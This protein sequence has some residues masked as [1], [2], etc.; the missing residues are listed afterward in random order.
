MA[1]FAGCIGG[2]GGSGDVEPA[3]DAENETTKPS[4][5]TGANVSTTW[6]NG[7]VN[8]VGN[9]AA[10][11]V[12]LDVC[13]NTFE[14]ELTANA[15]AIVVE[16]AWNASTDMRLSP[17]APDNDQTCE[18]VDPEGVLRVCRHPEP[19]NG[20]SPLRVEITDEQW[21]SVDD[22]WTSR[23]WPAQATDPVEI[24]LVATVVYDDTAPARIQHLGS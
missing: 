16:A 5:E 6:F 20:A 1:G 13:D 15:S 17:Y 24:T 3:S 7:S 10:E 8:G 9:E 18:D 12:C 23:L 4:N 11:Y 19:V 2:D 22:T 21:T 14:F